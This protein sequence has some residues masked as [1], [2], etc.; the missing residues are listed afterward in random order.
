MGWIS[1]K[2]QTLRAKYKI[3]QK[4]RAEVNAALQNIQKVYDT[5][6][7]VKVPDKE[8]ACIR[9]YQNTGMPMVARG[10][11][12]IPLYHECN[13]FKEHKICPV[14]LTEKCK[15]YEANKKYVTANNNLTIAKKDFFDCLLCR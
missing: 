11:M 7:W 13:S 9:Y 10:G 12:H 2:I 14:G 1:D 8:K 4:C 6:Q 3:V 15:W 5:A